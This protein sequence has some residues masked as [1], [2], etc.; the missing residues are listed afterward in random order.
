VGGHEEFQAAYVSYQFV[1]TFRN[2]VVGRSESRSDVVMGACG[3]APQ[4]VPPISPLI[5]PQV[6]PL[7]GITP[8]I[9]K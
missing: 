1:A 2:A 3:T 5:P 7:P 8:E 6:I 4:F 9:I